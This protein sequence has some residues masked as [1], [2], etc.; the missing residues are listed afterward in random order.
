MAELIAPSAGLRPPGV[1]LRNKSHD[2]AKVEIVV[3]AG[4]ELEVPEVVAKAAMAQSGAFAVVDDDLVPSVP[5]ADD[6][7]EAA[8]GTDSAPSRRVRRRA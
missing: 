6:A 4:A 8:A 1:R 7:E 3:P 5:P 2:V